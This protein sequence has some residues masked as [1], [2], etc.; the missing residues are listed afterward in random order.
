ML[1]YDFG[2]CLLLHNNSSQESIAKVLAGL[3]SQ[4]GRVESALQ[5]R[6]DGESS[7]DGIEEENA[8]IRRNLQGLVQAAESFHSNT[9]VILSDGAR[10][11]VWSGSV[12]GEPLSA[13]QHR[14]IRDWIPPPIIEESEH[15]EPDSS[16]AR[17]VTKIESPGDDD[18]DHSGKDS[19]ADSDDLERQLTMKFEE[20]A[21]K[22]LE[23]KDFEKAETFLRKL[24]DRGEHGDTSSMHMTSLKTWLAYACG[25]QDKWEEAESILV[26]IAMAKGTVD[27]MAL[28]GMN[29]LALV[30]LRTEDYDAAIRYCKRAIWGL[31]K[32]RGKTSPVFY[33][34]MA[35]LARIYEIKGD[36]A[37]AEGCRSL[38][39]YDYS[40]LSSRPLALEPLTWIETVLVQ[41]LPSF[42][43]GGPLLQAARTVSGGSFSST[44]EQ[45]TLAS[46]SEV[47]TDVQLESLATS[48]SSFTLPSSSEN[49]ESLI[50]KGQGNFLLFS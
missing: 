19:D 40:F 6:G 17:A 49:S 31:R 21:M 22:S 15:V 42:P 1:I 2:S 32:F 11:T 41:F 35:L 18:K 8:R 25:S 29:A 10:S 30:H 36:S 43:N 27:V 48:A 37:E 47:F 5:E 26:P 34:S 45:G 44:G 23:Q 14:S 12:I 13:E 50:N 16:V 20:L 28:H 3:K 33:E 4:I 9:S 46:S 38:I 39:L 7:K 24:V